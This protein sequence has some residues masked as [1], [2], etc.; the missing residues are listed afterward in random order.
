MPPVQHAKLAS[1]SS[2]RAAR[3]ACGVV[4]VMLGAAIALAMLSSSYVGS[5]S[6][7][8]HVLL[9]SSP[10]RLPP[11]PPQQPW[12]KSLPS[13]E[14]A[15]TVIQDVPPSSAPA[16]YM[17]KS[18]APTTP[19]HQVLPALTIAFP[20]NP[21]SPSP[22]QPPAS[23]ATRLQGRENLRERSPPI[24]CSSLHGD[25][26][27]CVQAYISRADG[28]GISLCEYLFTSRQCI[29]S[30]QVLSCPPPPPTPPSL[31][32]P[33]MLPPSVPPMP[34]VEQINLRF[35]QGGPGPN[36]A[37]AGVLVHTFDDITD[38][39]M[40]WLPCHESRWCG[41]LRDRFATSLLYPG[42]GDVYSKGDGGFVI[43]PTAA[44]ILCSY[45]GDG[46]SMAKACQLPGVSDSCVP[47]CGGGYDK[48]DIV[49]K[50]SWCTCA[51]GDFLCAWKPFELE[52]M[53][54]QQKHEAGNGFLNQKGYNEVSHG[55]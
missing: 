26:S 41:N 2:Q 43:N 34:M 40:P 14:V 18:A 37:T 42:H 7:L 22:S 45:H 32:Q 15:H 30:A 16:T 38:M 9:H 13:A 33:P 51:R 25:A 50:T 49:Q 27:Q 20:P 29:A 55:M 53:M 23:C 28:Q 6:M 21:S 8:V 44:K 31:P 39:S 11:P 4:L 47:G 52:Q 36:L 17:D 48:C 12:W 54:Q 24:R 19:T 5:A 35:T 1:T 46:H 3:I 10:D